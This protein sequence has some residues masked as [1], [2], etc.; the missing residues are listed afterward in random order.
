MPRKYDDKSSLTVGQQER[1]V[2]LQ[3]RGMK[4]RD[5]AEVIGAEPRAVGQ[6]LRT[7]NAW[8]MKELEEDRRAKAAQQIEILD[9]LVGD[10]MHQW[11]KSKSDEETEKVVTFSGSEND[12]GAVEIKQR[13]EKTKRGRTGDPAIIGQIRGALADV[14]GILGLDAPKA[15]EVKVGGVEGS[16]PIQIVEVVV[17]PGG[18]T[19]GA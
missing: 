6:F 17:P 15:T 12:D 11:E 1:C 8:V 2:Q 10:L 7:F 16:K 3:E 18:Q 9:H 14:R 5:I 4:S 19:D 13:V